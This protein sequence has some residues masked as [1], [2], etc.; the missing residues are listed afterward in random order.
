MGRAERR[1][2]KKVCLLGD[3]A[4]GKTSLVRRS[5]EG[6]FDERYLSTIGVKVDR[7]VLHLP[8]PDGA[9]TL[10]LMLWDLAGG[11]TIGPVSPSYYRGSAGAV[12]VCDVTRPETLE[13]T[14]HYAEGFQAVNPGAPWVL[15]ANKVDLVEEREV[16]DEALAQAADSAGVACFLT[17]AKTGESV[18]SLLSWL[19]MLLVGRPEGE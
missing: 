15:A 14:K 17:S 5:V 3:F 10:N 13:G 7:K 9:V 18:E 8:G 2:T 1:L 16:G 4:V 6:R 19:G 12:I 11:P